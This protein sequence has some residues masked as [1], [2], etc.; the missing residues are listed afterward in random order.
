MISLAWVD[1]GTEDL[2]FQLEAAFPALEENPGCGSRGGSDSGLGWLPAESLLMGCGGRRVALR[3]HLL[4]LAGSCPWGADAWQQVLTT[5]HQWT[6]SSDF[7]KNFVV[8]LWV[9]SISWHCPT[10]SKG[11]QPRRLTFCPT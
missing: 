7:P 5:H 4:T 8:K 6:D 11:E 1:P 3:P 10:A 2:Q 9:G